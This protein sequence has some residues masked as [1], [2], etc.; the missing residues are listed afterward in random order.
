M[1]RV[2]NPR[3]AHHAQ[4]LCSQVLDLHGSGPLSG[5]VTLKWPSFI[6]TGLSWLPVPTCLPQQ[7]GTAVPGRD[8]KVQGSRSSYISLVLPCIAAGAAA[9][10]Y[11]RVL[12]L[13]TTLC[14]ARC[15]WHLRGNQP[16]P[17][18]LCLHGGAKWESRVLSGMAGAP[19][20]AIAEPSA[21]Q[22]Q[23]GRL[24]IATA[25]KHSSSRAICSS[26]TEGNKLRD[27]PVSEWEIQTLLQVGKSKQTAR[28]RNLKE[29]GSNQL[30]KN[31]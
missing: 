24:G 30:G 9:P 14:L 19:F 21:Y 17:T 13:S 4:E 7:Q 8:G 25:V 18:Q 28:M 2:S 11:W 15:C 31:I 3:K 16:N 20:C 10:W 5:H 1:E 26:C 22:M 12:V 27:H 6:P 29:I 23:Q